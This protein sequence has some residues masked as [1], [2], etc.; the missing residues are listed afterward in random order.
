MVSQA[1]N[2]E[3]DEVFYEATTCR[4][5]PTRGVVAE[6]AETCGPSNR[7]V[8]LLGALVKKHE[9]GS[10]L[11][12]QPLTSSLTTPLSTPFAKST[13]PSAELS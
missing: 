2:L 1:K 12:S 3:D 9:V 5:G 4:K 10:E 7:G 11:P 13:P 8:A 6:A